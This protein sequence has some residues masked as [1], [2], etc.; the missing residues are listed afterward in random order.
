M[1]RNERKERRDRTTS[2]HVNE[3]LF[4]SGIYNLHIT[5]VTATLYG[6]MDAGEG[7]SEPPPLRA[8]SASVTQQPRYAYRTSCAHTGVRSVCTTQCSLP[9]RCKSLLPPPC[10]PPRPGI[11]GRSSSFIQKMWVHRPILYNSETATPQ[12]G[13]L[14]KD[15]GTVILKP[16]TRATSRSDFPSQALT[17]V[18]ESDIYS[19]YFKSHTV[20][21]LVR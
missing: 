20:L 15:I 9:S 6:D 3:G 14:V 8:R 1:I 16:V 12:H 11:R 13:P 19:W 4:S 21:A 10:L 2:Y 17:Y 18:S 7:L 5:G